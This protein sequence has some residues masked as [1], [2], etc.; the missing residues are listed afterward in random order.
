MAKKVKPCPGWLAT[1]ADL[2][3][4]LMA[5]FVLLFAMSTLDADKYEQVVRSLTESLAGGDDLTKTQLQYFNSQTEQKQQEQ[6][7]LEKK[8]ETLVEDL[9]PLFESL[10]ETYASNDNPD[11][12]IN[13]DPEKNQIKVTFA[14][15]ISFASGRSELKPKLIFLLR[16]LKV[17]LNDELMVKAVGHTDAIPVRG[18]R[19]ESNWELS[20][21]RAA[22]VINR[23]IKD[24]IISP[25]QGEAIGLADTQPIIDEKSPEAYA[26]NRRVEIILL[27]LKYRD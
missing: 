5:V 7:S 12:K 14:E 2:M 3:S 24:R 15:Q 10:I 27:P 22:A 4:L 8:G 6:Q 26:K 21:S 25:I 20:S 17:Y 16:K 1:F 23:L 19:Y 18:G 13:Y 9:K 11:I